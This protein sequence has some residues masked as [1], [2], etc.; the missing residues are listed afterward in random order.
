MTQEARDA[1]ASIDHDRINYLPILEFAQRLGIDLPLK[2][3]SHRE[4]V[5]GWARILKSRTDPDQS[6]WAPR[7]PDD[8]FVEWFE[9]LLKMTDAEC[10]AWKKEAWEAH[11]KNAKKKYE[12]NT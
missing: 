6:W 5:A 8:I 2:V 3:I 9:A 7:D 12:R 4:A 10:E 1:W 11:L